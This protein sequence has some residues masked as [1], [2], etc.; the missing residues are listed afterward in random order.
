MSSSEDFGDALWRRHRRTA[1]SERARQDAKVSFGE[2]L[3]ARHFEFASMLMRRAGARGE[4][5]AMQR[6]FVVARRASLADKAERASP[7]VGGSDAATS[8]VSVVSSIHSD[9]IGGVASTSSVRPMLR[10]EQAASSLSAMPRV[11]S[12]PAPVIATRAID[13]P[14]SPANGVGRDALDAGVLRIQTA[15]GVDSDRSLDRADIV[16][17]VS[18]DDPDAHGSRV[19][20]VAPTGVGAGESSVAYAHALPPSDS[21]RHDASTSTLAMN[22]PIARSSVESDVHRPGPSADS[23]ARNMRLARAFAAS[24]SHAEAASR[25]PLAWSSASGD[26]QQALVSADASAA[27]RSAPSESFLAMPLAP[28]DA[29]ATN[30][31]LGRDDSLSS[32]PIGSLVSSNTASVGTPHVRSL[33]LGNSASD[34]SVALLGGSAMNRSHAVSASHSALYSASQP[35][36]TLARSVTPPKASSTHSPIMRS[37]TVT[38]SRGGSTS[39]SPLARSVAPTEP[40]TLHLPMPLPRSVAFADASAVQRPTAQSAAISVSNFVLAFPMPLVQTAASPID[41]T[42]AS[43]THLTTTR[44]SAVGDSSSQLPLARSFALPD[45]SATR[46]VASSTQ[47]P[48]ARSSANRVTA[49]ALPFV[50]SN[51]RIPSLPGQA[52]ARNVAS[53]DSLRLRGHIDKPLRASTPAVKAQLPA[54]ALSR[55]PLRMQH[56]PHDASLNGHNTEPGVFADRTAAQYGVLSPPATNNTTKAAEPAAHTTATPNASAPDPEELA[57]QAWRLILDKLAIEQERRGYAS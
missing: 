44:L 25:M 8:D 39:H 52:L 12:M 26:G 20:S 53:S 5:D 37:S 49:S 27:N 32:M 45:A 40:S 54:P 7:R 24:V 17:D 3:H 21:D 33:P 29:N 46:A 31:S 18:T 56:V 42:E 16:S 50:S 55:F 11:E 9:Q 4:G 57:E 38:D 35:T 43:G 28:L 34:T 13:V 41:S 22:M 51:S 1:V 47:L 48:L 19:A 10:A 30:R 15:R 6:P 2:G 14:L 23:E 36:M